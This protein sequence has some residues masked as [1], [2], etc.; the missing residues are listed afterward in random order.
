MELCS[1]PPFCLGR[2]YYGNRGRHYV[3]QK[4]PLLRMCS[5]IYTYAQ[6]KW[7]TKNTSV[8]TEMFHIAAITVCVAEKPAKTPKTYGLNVSNNIPMCSAG[9]TYVVPLSIGL[10]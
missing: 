10:R 4:I 5:V 1:H 7:R 3:A 9:H 8:P 6:A 2:Q